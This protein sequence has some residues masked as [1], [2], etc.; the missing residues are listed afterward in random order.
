LAVKGCA[1]GA[2]KLA[3]LAASPPVLARP[4]GRLQDSM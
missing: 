4:S 1:V 2:I 3:A